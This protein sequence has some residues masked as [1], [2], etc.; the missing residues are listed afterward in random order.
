MGIK[1]SRLEYWNYLDSFTKLFNYA[2]SNAEITIFDQ[3]M[4]G[5]LRIL[6][7]YEDVSSFKNMFLWVFSANSAKITEYFFLCDHFLCRDWNRRSA[8]NESE[9]GGTESQSSLLV[10]FIIPYTI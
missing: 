9:I 5:R 7:H 1:I 3:N 8:V 2:A 6:N 4:S 10:I